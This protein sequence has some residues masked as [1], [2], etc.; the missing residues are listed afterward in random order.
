MQL[1]RQFLTGLP[2]VVTTDQIVLNKLL[3]TAQF[4][5]AQGAFYENTIVQ[6]LIKCMT[7]DSIALRK[8]VI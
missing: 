8:K 4:R 5:T 2:G 1:R 3:G 7:E 6:D